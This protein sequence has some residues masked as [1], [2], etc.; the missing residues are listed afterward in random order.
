M[1]QVRELCSCEDAS[2]KALTFETHRMVT[3]K[4]MPSWDL[5]YTLGSALDED[6]NERSTSTSFLFDPLNPALS[7]GPSDNDVR[8]RFVGSA[9][10]KLPYGVQASA[11]F[12]IRS[13]IP[14]N[15]GITYSQTGVPGGPNSLNGLPSMTGNIP[16]FVDGNGTIIDLTQASGMTLTQFSAFLQA[17]NGRLIGRNAFRQPAWH[18]LD[19]R[20]SKTFDLPA[21]ARHTQVQLIAEG[22]NLL[23]T[24]N[25][26]VGSGNQ[27]LYK[28]AFSQTTGLYTITSLAGPTGFGVTN[29]YASTPDPRQAQV[30]VKFIF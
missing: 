2:Y 28:A 11:I 9:T 29:S 6:T 24:R 22:F 4:T 16:V 3:S 12:Q 14:Y 21:G 26:F 17:K 13:G 23:G 25:L 8:H 7:R 20:L 10:Y 27:N 15:G 5:S 30:A 18:T 19:L 1:G